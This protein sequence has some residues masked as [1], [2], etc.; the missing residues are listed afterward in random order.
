MEPFLLD[1]EMNQPGMLKIIEYFDNR[2][3]ELRL[4]NDD[5]NNCP[6]KLRARID[7]IKTFQKKLS[8][9]RKA[10]VVSKFSA[11]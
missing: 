3:A 9:G 10:D 8:P 5:F 2:L 11:L 6:I 1:H 4:Q 7:E